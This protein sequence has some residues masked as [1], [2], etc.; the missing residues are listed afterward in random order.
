[1]KKLLAG[2]AFLTFIF[3]C[4]LKINR[5]THYFKR[6]N[7]TFRSTK[8]PADT[9]IT[10]LQISDLHN[11]VFGSDNK[12]LI[13]AI[14]DANA[15][16][17]V[18]TGDLIDKKTMTFEHIFPLIEQLTESNQHVY[19]V[20]GNHEWENGRTAEFFNALKKRHVTILNNRHTR[21]TKGNTIINLVG[22]DDAA[23]EHDNVREAFRNLD[24]KNYTILLSHSPGIIN[25]DEPIS[26]DLVLSGHTHGG[27]IRLPLIGT[28]IAPGQGFFPAYDKGTFQLTPNLYLYIDSGMGTTRIP[29]RFFNQSQLSLITVTGEATKQ[30]TC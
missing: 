20:S 12:R 17:I 13:K 28:L 11:H 7:V 15:D 18:L 2:L 3:I 29:V 8:L 23:T 10:I 6:E 26:A 9:L 5:D 25:Q 16:L 14:Q 27:Q 21:M 4:S 30:T 24:C 19:F 1:M 22:I